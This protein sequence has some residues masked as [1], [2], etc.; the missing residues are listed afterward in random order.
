M[1]PG[2]RLTSPVVV[3]RVGAREQVGALWNLTNPCG[4][5]APWSGMVAK[6]LPLK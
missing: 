2:A 6:F 5:C 1:R 3:P 4:A